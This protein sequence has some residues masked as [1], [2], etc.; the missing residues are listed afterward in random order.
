MY[1]CRCYNTVGVLVPDIEIIFY[2]LRFTKGNLRE[3][4]FSGRN[5]NKTAHKELIKCAHNG[6]ILLS[7]SV[8]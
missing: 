5:V 2:F 8:I 7:K 4:A 6:D 1:E 3:R